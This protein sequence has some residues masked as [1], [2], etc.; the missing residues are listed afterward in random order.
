MSIRLYWTKMTAADPP[1]GVG[2]IELFAADQPES[3]EPQELISARVL[4][5]DTNVKS[6]ALL[7]IAALSKARALLDDEI[8][9]LEG[10]YRASERSQR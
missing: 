6:L 10:L 9:R 2:Q 3:A 8:Q 7:Q 5:A 4:V 1:S